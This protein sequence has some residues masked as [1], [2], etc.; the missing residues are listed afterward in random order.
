MQTLLPAPIAAL[1]ESLSYD[2]RVAYLDK[3]A[4]AGVRADVFVNSATALGFRVSWN[5][6]HGTP[7][8]TWLH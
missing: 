4:A 1:T 5:H 2:E 6:A 3:I 7:I 8:L